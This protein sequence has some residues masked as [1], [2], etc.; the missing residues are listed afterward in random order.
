MTPNATCDGESITIHE[1][2]TYQGGYDPEAFDSDGNFR[3]A[4]VPMAC[5]SHCI[6]LYM[7]P[8]AQL[9]PV[10]KRTRL[11]SQMDLLLGQML[12]IPDLP[13]TIDEDPDPLW[14]GIRLV[15]PLAPPDDPRWAE[16]E[17]RKARGEAVKPPKATLEQW[18]RALD[19]QMGGTLHKLSTT[20]G[21]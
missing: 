17:K 19:L 9:G 6:E 7:R 18:M 14:L 15:P 4:R 5:T 13:A 8:H 16:I 2:V 3:Y 10:Q 1:H 21:A 11:L 20:L 12:S